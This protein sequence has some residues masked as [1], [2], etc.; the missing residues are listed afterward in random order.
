[1]SGGHFSPDSSSYFAG[2]LDDEITLLMNEAS[3][4]Y[5]NETLSRLRDLR[6]RARWMADMH[7]ATDKLFSDDIG[8]EEFNRL[9]KEFS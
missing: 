8:E 9:W 6:G 2:E 7:R 1:M 5:S 4:Q 3:P